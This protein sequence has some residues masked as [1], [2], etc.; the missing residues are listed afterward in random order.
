MLR[1]AL[2]FRVNIRSSATGLNGW[3]LG[4]FV[5]KQPLGHKLHRL[6]PRG[7]ATNL[8]GP[9]LRLKRVEIKIITLSARVVKLLLG[10]EYHVLD[11]T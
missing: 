8:C 9:P 3:C 11:L 2:V 6:H 7:M 4:V 1:L 10:L 5:K